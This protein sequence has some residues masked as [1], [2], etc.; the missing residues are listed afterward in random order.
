MNWNEMNTNNNNQIEKNMG[1]EL[2]ARQHDTGKEIQT[3]HF[4]FWVAPKAKEH[5]VGAVR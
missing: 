2:D 5:L 3:E 4:F 1:S